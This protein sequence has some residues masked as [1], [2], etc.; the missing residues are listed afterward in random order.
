MKEFLITEIKPYPT[1]GAF[2]E[3][4]AKFYNDIVLVNV[5]ATASMRA[6][7]L[8]ST[9]RKVAKVHQNILVFYKGD[10]AK[11]KKSY[12]DLP[13]IHRYH[14]NILVFYKGDINEIKENYKV[15]KDELFLKTEE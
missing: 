15:V 7:R 5:V 1:I 10:L 12:Q 6:R 3:T 9:N 14:E 2:E 4:G 8:F 11:T 13:Q